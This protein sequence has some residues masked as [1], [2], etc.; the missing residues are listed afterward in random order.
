MTAMLSPPALPKQAESSPQ[1]VEHGILT[2]EDPVELLEGLLV[3]KMTKHPP[4]VVSGKLTAI[5]LGRLIPTPCHVATQD[6]F[7]AT[8][9]APEPD[10][11]VVRGSPRDYSSRHPLPQDLA[12][13]VEVADSSVGRDRGMKRRVY[14]RAGV[15]A[16]WIVVLPERAVEVYTDPSGPA[17][18]P[19]YATVRRFADGDAVPV[20]IDGRD[21]GTVA[22]ADLLP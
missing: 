8:T 12:L 21:V 2:D 3:L 14:A 1:D 6:A 11:S 7:T 15:P 17:D 19:A 20:V 5:T 16:Y 10:V 22:V 13:V 18:A 4:H 9:S